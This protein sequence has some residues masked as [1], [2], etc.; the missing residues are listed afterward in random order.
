M[1]C[2]RTRI[3]TPRIAFN[4][5]GVVA[6]SELCLK[7]HEN[8]QASSSCFPSRRH[9]LRRKCDNMRM[10]YD[11]NADIDVSI[12][13]CCLLPL[14]KNGVVEMRDTAI[15][16]NLQQCIQNPEDYN[17]SD[18]HLY[19]RTCLRWEMYTRFT[20]NST[21]TVYHYS[22]WTYSVSS[23]KFACSCRFKTLRVFCC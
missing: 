12:S 23:K 21:G 11:V 18:I 19:A 5:L 10:K 16:R 13:C 4:V 15:A 14:V 9:V 22:V 2:H 3:N 1:L 7:H 8:R 6:V 20:E 17:F